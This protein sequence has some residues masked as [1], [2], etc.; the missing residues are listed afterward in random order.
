MKHFVDRQETLVQDAIEGLLATSRGR[1]SRLD[2]FPDIKVVVRTDWKK[3]K[4]AVISGGGSGHEPAH[5]GFVGKGLLTAAVCG[6]VFASPSVEAVLAAIRATAGEP[7]VVLVVKNYTGDRLN[8]GLASERAKSEGYKVRMVVVSDDISLPDSAQPRGI[9]GTLFVHKVAGFLAEQGESLE[10]VAEGAHEAAKATKSLGLALTTCHPPGATD[11]ETI[12][13]DRVELGLGIHGEPGVE[14]IAMAEAS[15]LMEKVCA[16]LSEEVDG[17]QAVLLNNLGAV[18]PLEMLLLA[19]SF[20][21]TEL[22]RRTKLLMGPSHLMTSYD[23][24]GFSVSSIPL[25]ESIREALTAPV[26]S[27]FWCAPVEPSSGPT[28]ALEETR[29][30]RFDASENPTVRAALVSIC[31]ALKKSRE[32]LNSLDAKIGDGDAGDTF[33]TA[34]RAVE[35]HLD[36]LPLAEPKQL[37]RAISQ[38][39]SRSMGGSSGALL[40]IFTQAASANFEEGNWARSLLAGARRMMDYG[41]AKVGDRTML[42]ALIPA[43]EALRD[44]SSVSECAA[45]AEEKARGTARLAQAGVGRSSYLSKDTLQGVED[46]G[47]RAVAV[48]FKALLDA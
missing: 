2:G 12:E 26:E 8:F 48:A 18:P 30:T 40:S 47:A 41:G 20:L 24:N 11:K 15:S 16:E 10:K 21:G 28:I 3:D 17:E 5:A 7:G 39:L 46:P 45:V 6:E 1:L 23:M 32:K 22:G 37:L 43:L 35:K 29:E 14:T 31:S 33:Y 44:G 34:A 42:D 27:D 38:V 9:A 25:S 13:Q 4:V 19:K 36:E